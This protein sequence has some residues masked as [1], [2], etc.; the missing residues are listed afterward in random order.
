MARGQEVYGE[1]PAPELDCRSNALLRASITSDLVLRTALASVLSGALL[2]GTLSS[3]GREDARRLAF[4]AE[5]ADAQDPK[6]VFERPPERVKVKR[7]RHQDDLGGLGRV[8]VVHFRTPY[9]PLNPALRSEYARAGNRNELVAAHHWR[10]SDGPRRTLCVIHGFGASPVWFNALFFSLKAFFAEGWDV[11]LYTLP[12]HGGRGA[13][14]VP[15]GIGM[16]GAGGAR[17][18]EAIVQAVFDFRI[19]LDHL[20][21]Y[22]APRVGVTGLSLGGYISALLA[23]VEE[24]LDF[25]IPNAPVTWMPALISSWLPANAV[26]AAGRRVLGISEE[27]LERSFALHSPL[28]YPP[29]VPKRRLMIVRGLGDKLAPPEQASMLWEHWGRPRMHSFAGSHVLHFGRS[30]YLAEMRRLMLRTSTR[31]A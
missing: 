2:R 9:R 25:V 15:D 12:F 6:R 8:D 11:L 17:I 26:V 22:G 18:H 27:L 28:T 21:R 24:R 3:A 13:R 30:A 19:L 5:L 16:F 7:T 10:H 20:E 29:V 14:L 31:A 23:A 1:P 4:Y